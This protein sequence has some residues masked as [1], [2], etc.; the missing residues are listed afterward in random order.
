MDRVETIRQLLS[1]AFSP[2]HLDISDESH[3]HR[4][5]AGAAAGGGHFN[6]TIV[7]TQFEG[8]AT[9]ARHRRVYQAVDNLMP[10]EIH[11][12]S[13]TANT[14]EEHSSAKA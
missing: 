12:L 11:A 13:I 7:S 3:F 8:L 6:V 9:L 4:G 1:E 10:A 5:H 2:T 14:P